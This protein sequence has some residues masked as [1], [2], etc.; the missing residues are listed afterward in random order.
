MRDVL[1]MSVHASDHRDTGR[2]LDAVVRTDGVVQ[3][4]QFFADDL[5]GFGHFSYELLQM[6]QDDYTRS[7]VL[8]F[9]LR[10]SLVETLTQQASPVKSMLCSFSFRE[11]CFSTVGAAVQ[12][13]V[14][15]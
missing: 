1:H 6:M 4:F 2:R 3:G 5:S 7:P 12:E 13:Q 14:L 10:P 11:T 9:G 8:L 15:L